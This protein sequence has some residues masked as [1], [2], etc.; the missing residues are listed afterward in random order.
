MF[1]DEL[2][3]D[4]QREHAS[5][6]VN[7]ARLAF[8]RYREPSLGAKP[9]GLPPMAPSA[10]AAPKDGSYAPGQIVQ[11]HQYGIGK[12][13]DVSGYGA[14]KRVKIRFASAGE[15]TFVADKVQLTVVSKA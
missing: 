11:H 9:R 12:I 4:V 7:T 10:A 8:D 13:T 2:P 5:S 14:L 3:S 6:A 1:L 15:K